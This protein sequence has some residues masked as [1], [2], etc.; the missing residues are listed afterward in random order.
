MKN[1]EADHA[2]V[3]AFRAEMERRGSGAQTTLAK[4]TGL[5][6]GLINDILKGRTFGSLETQQSLAQAL[7]HEILDD[8]LESGRRLAREEC[9][10]AIKSG[11]PPAFPTHLEIPSLLEILVE[12]RALR[13][14]LEKTRLELENIR[15]GRPLGESDPEAQ[16]KGEK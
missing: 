7:G 11:N 4:R 9:L 1:R 5:S 6:T 16:I 14:E 12:N 2:F 3:R 10:N 13:L 15:H 8:F